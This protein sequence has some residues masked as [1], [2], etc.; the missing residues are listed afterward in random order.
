MDYTRLNQI[1]RKFTLGEKFS[2]INL[3]QIKEEFKLIHPTGQ[4]IIDVCIIKKLGDY[5]YHLSNIVKWNKSEGLFDQ[6]KIIQLSS[7]PLW[8]YDFLPVLNI[9]QNQKL[10]MESPNSTKSMVLEQLDNYIRTKVFDSTNGN[11]DDKLKISYYLKIKNELYNKLNLVYKTWESTW[12][13]VEE[14]YE[15]LSDILEENFKSIES[16]STFE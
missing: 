5:V 9:L 14:E 8:E 1:N 6:I 16:D 10:L 11:F 7:F 15:E 13:E 12:D 3:E 2:S 4:T